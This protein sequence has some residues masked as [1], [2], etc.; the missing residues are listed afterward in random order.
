[1]SRVLGQA[2]ASASRVA[3]EPLVANGAASV[4]RLSALQSIFEEAAA[5]FSKT[6]LEKTGSSIESSVEEVSAIRIGETQ[7]IDAA[8]A[9]VGVYDIEEL[10]SKAIVGIDF[11]LVLCL[12]EALFG[13]N[14]S[15]PFARKDRTATK[16]E[17]RAAEFAMTTFVKSFQNSLSRFVDANFEL[18]Q[19]APTA[20][21]G[22]LGRKGSVVVLCTCRV[23]A[24]GR[25]GE[26]VMAIARSALDPYRDALSRDLNSIG[27]NEDSTW[28]DNLRNQVVRATV[29]VSATMERK[30]LTLGD[31]ARFRIGQVIGLPFSP[32]SLILVKCADRRLFNCELGQKDGCY[33]VR[34]E[35]LIDDKEEFIKSIL[36]E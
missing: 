8:L 26:V 30:G 32:T 22:A 6:L 18:E 4:N 9:V 13:S 21:W 15:A 12:I 23:R 17:L 29:T 5:R 3:Q 2:D 7:A 25:E 35:E 34:I 36:K 31:V 27:A 14:V 33:T 11:E 24:C 20:D 16:V 19:V 28:A 10:R 1:M